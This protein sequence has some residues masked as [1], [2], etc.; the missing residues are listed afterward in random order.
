MGEFDMKKWV[1]I[2]LTML[3]FAVFGGCYSS[4]GEWEDRIRQYLDEESSELD[5]APEYGENESI[6][7][8]S[9]VEDFSAEDSSTEDSVPE[10]GMEQMYTYT[11]MMEEL[12]E[13]SIL[14][15]ELV[16]LD[17]LGY[18]AMGREIPLVKLGNG[19]AEV[20]YVAAIHGCEF[21]TVNYMMRCLREYTETAA[22]WESYGGYNIAE[23]LQN[24]TFY[25]VPMANPDGFEISNHEEEPLWLC[26]DLEA[27]RYDYSCNG[28]GA[29]LNR[30]FPIAW[31]EAEGG[32]QPDAAMSKGPYEA[33]EPE[34]QALIQLCEEHD[35][36]R[37]FSFHNYGHCVYWQD[38]YSGSVPG[39]AEL[40]EL[41]EDVCGFYLP[42][43]TSDPVRYGGGFENWFRMRYNR[44]GFCVEL[45][46]LE[47]DTSVFLSDFED[48]VAWYSTRYAMLLGLQ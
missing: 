29:N 14:Y 38:T 42:D 12:A 8:I 6:P 31:E 47:Y 2:V 40:A 41:L 10:P 13:L 32:T 5:S 15:P 20:L 48:A 18:S 28:N 46:L 39:D 44:P 9:Y 17:T 25:I 37:M 27:A 33:S 24:Y 16:R 23:I 3:L 11:G 26:P 36:E 4:L 43:A 21:S 35:F 7:D 45:G 22:A 34:T 30:N 19:E 1:W